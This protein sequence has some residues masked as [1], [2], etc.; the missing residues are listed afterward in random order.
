MGITRQLSI[1]AN[2]D[3]SQIIVDATNERVIAG[4]QLY[5]VTTFTATA[6]TSQCD[7][8]IL[9]SHATVAIALTMTSAPEA[10]RY[11]HIIN[12]SASGTAAHTVK[13]PSGVTFDG[14]NN[15]AT[16]NAPDENLF[17]V[18]R[19]ATRWQIIVNNGSVGLSS[20]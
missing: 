15:T 19:S 5:P 2:D 18:A 7:G 20:T 1:S 13:L 11:L 4:V 8:I 9:L 6:S 10:G 14:T 16:L 3:P 12:S 17:L